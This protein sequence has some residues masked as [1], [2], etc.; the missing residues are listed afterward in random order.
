MGNSIWGP[1]DTGNAYIRSFDAY[2]YLLYVIL[3]I[4]M[5]DCMYIYVVI[6]FL[7]NK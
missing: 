5:L 6:I 3:V 7:I 4:V 2:I 1:Y